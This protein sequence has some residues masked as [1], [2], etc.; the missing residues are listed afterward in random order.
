LFDWKKQGVL[1][2]F[3]QYLLALLDEQDKL[4]HDIIFIDGTFMPSMNKSTILD[5]K[6]KALNRA[7][8][9]L[10][11]ICVIIAYS[12]SYWWDGY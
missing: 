12:S 5:G 1:V 10:S 8:W 4:L 11:Q 3:H 6:K 9:H 2:E 7:L